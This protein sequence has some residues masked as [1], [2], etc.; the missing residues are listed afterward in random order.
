MNVVAT[1]QGRFIE[2]QGTGE[3]NTFSKE[4]LDKLLV[5]AQKGIKELVEIQKTVLK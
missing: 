2:V 5:L 3:N 1:E 4:D